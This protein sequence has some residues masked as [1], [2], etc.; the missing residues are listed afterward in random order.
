MKKIF[1]LLFSRLI[2]TCLLILL[3]ILVI[4]YALW[5]LS[6]YFV[7]IYIGFILLSFLI[8]IYVMNEDRSP[9]LKL[10]W[11]LL[12]FLLPVFGGAFYLMFAQNR[13]YKKDREKY[14]KMYNRRN[15]TALDTYQ[16]DIDKASKIYGRQSYY[17]ATKALAPAHKNTTVKYFSV[18]EKMYKQMLE[19]LKAA[20]HFIFIEYFII[21]EG[22]MW[23][24]ILDILVEKV[25]E[26]VKVK[27]IFDDIG[28][29]CT[30]PSGYAHFMK[31]LGIETAIFNPFKPVLS[32]GHNN[33]D[34]RKIM[35]I[36]GYIGYT[37]GINIADEY[38]N[39]YPKYGHWKDTAVRL[40]G[41]AVENLTDIFLLSWNYFGKATEKLD[42]YLPHVYHKE[43]FKSDGFVQP[44]GDT[45]I[46]KELLGETIYLNLIYGATDYI[47]INSPYLIVSYE[48]IQALC[49]AAKRGVDVRITT[50]YI[51][52]KWYVH[53]VTQSHYK[54][55]M[56]AGVKIY[57]YK[58][59]F[60]HAK[61]FVVDDV[62]AVIGTINLDYRSL[63]HH[64]EDGVWL[65]KNSAILDMKE[66]YQKT[67]HKCIRIKKEMV[68][69]M[70]WHKRWV[71]NIIQ[72]FSPLL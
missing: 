45:P 53:I 38:I 62:A 47:Y 67:L 11:I 20:K 40:E 69:N 64:F 51:P 7:Y 34:H 32:I 17:I 31:D 14:T 70:P 54:V 59:G 42:K 16:K 25:R 52:D 5:F 1:S 66:D 36:D 21:G 26:G 3:Q 27:L 35:V 37:G 15:K 30:L 39:E 9:S 55:L 6:D 46:D 2:M 10:P 48:M 60:N 61:S 24:G 44:F 68:E 71:R 41:E 50:P 29:I 8:L 23:D 49:I 22:K 43:R 4:V 18:G 33:R 72:F 56:E 57:E 63:I 58:P 12:I 19:D 13:F 65:Y 28:C